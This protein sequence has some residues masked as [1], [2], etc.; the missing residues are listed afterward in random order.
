VREK[1]REYSAADN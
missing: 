1:K